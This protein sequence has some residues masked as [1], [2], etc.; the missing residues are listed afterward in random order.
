M[1]Y[2]YVYLGK[3]TSSGWAW[4][5]IYSVKNLRALD[6]TGFRCAVMAK[7]GFHYIAVS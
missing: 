3:E 2:K 4:D 7:S 1:S 6:S 5:V